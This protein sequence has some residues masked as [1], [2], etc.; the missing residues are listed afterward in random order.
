[1]WPVNIV[2]FAYAV[3]SRNSLQQG[4]VD[5]A[6]RLGRVAKLLSVVALVGGVLIIIASCV[7]NLGGDFSPAPA[8]CQ[9]LP[10]VGLPSPHTSASPALMETLTMSQL[11]VP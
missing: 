2:A 1:M 8:S 11:C 4:D 5:G 3:M 9:A 7:I 6:Q 10:T